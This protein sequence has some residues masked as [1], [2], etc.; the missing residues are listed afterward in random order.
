MSQETYGQQQ[1]KLFVALFDYDPQTMSPNQNAINDE[2]PFTEGQIIKVRETLGAYKIKFFYCMRN[3]K[4]ARV[5]DEPKIGGHNLGPLTLQLM[6]ALF[7]LAVQL[8]SNTS[9]Y[10]FATLTRLQ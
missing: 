1:S 2:L 9:T 3:S 5:E 4:R 8:Q 10:S 7:L 6:Y